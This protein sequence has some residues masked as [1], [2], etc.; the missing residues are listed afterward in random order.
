MKKG[1]ADAP[2]GQSWEETLK[3]DVVTALARDGG[4]HARLG[5]LAP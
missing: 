4:E 5:T 1:P 3:G 2:P